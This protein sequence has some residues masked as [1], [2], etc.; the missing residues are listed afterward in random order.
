MKV[1]DEM[2]QRFLS[3]KLPEDFRPDAGI[4]FDP[5]FNVAFNAKRG[6]PPQKHEPVGTNLL[7]AEQAR[8]MLE[9][10]LADAP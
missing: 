1:T 8:Q 10:V 5:Y 7:N 2:V 3:W 9:H 6:L 4:R